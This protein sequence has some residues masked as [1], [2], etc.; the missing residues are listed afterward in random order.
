MN[1]LYELKYTLRM[2]RKKLGFS[3]LCVL[4]IALGFPIALP[5]YSIVK[6]F[7]YAS[8]PYSGGDRIVVL[9][10]LDTRTNREVGDTT[11]DYFLFNGIKERSRSFEKLGAYQNIV[12]NISDGEFAQQYFGHRVTSEFLSYAE[13]NPI[14]GRSLLPEDESS[15][16][17]PVVLISYRIWQEYYT[18]DPEIVGKIARVNAQP[19]TII[20][21]MP[22]GFKYPS[23]AE[24][25]LPFSIPSFSEPGTQ[26]LFVM[27][28]ILNEGVSRAEASVELALIMQSLSAEAPGFYENRSA[29]A[30]RFTQ[31]GLNNGAWLIKSVAITAICLFLVICIN[32][33]NLLILR[34]N[35]RVSELAIRSA[36]GAK[37]LSL[38][39][40]VLLESFLVCFCGAMLGISFAGWVLNFLQ[41]FLLSQSLDGRTLP[42]WWNFGFTQEVFYLSTILMLTLWLSSGIFAAWRASKDGISTVL[43]KNSQMGGGTSS[44][45]LTQSLVGIQIVLSFFLLV[46]S[47]VYVFGFQ[48][49]LPSSVVSNPDNYLTATFD[50]DSARYR[51]PNQRRQY[52]SELVQEL[53]QLNEF[54]EISIATA[55]PGGGSEYSRAAVGDAGEM[56]EDAPLMAVNWIDSQY[57]D[58]ISFELFGGRNFDT[59]DLPNGDPVAIV[60]ESFA[61][62]ML[63][64]SDS[65]LGKQ[66]RLKDFSGIG[67]DFVTIIGVAPLASYDNSALNISQAPIIYRPIAQQNTASALKLIVKLNLATETP[68]IE[69]ENLVRES[70]ALIDRDVPFY[71]FELMSTPIVLNVL[72]IRTLMIMFAAAAVGSLLLAVISI[73][74]LISRTVHARTSEIGIR[75]AIGSPDSAIRGMFLKQALLY[76]I[77]AVIVGGGSAV[78]VINVLGS[79][80]SS[81]LNFVQ[82]LTIVFPSVTAAI[83]LL[84]FYASYVPVR[85]VVAMEP[86]EALHYE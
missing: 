10:Q 47:G 13:T 30:V 27:S 71:T 26:P 19:H 86:G 41:G 58:A 65:L 2:I 84:V 22:D 15:G 12:T 4:V 83:S 28:G 17:E 3:I 37:R 6:N 52:R 48:G 55:L 57:F 56:A 23:A 64:A 25:W 50:L 36:M 39:S 38:I 49:V 73:Y 32:V 81:A 7:A 40:H 67:E 34:A 63:M 31:A 69:L 8:L 20:G 59:G 53:S 42:F 60:S 35:E 54:S 78:L 5:L 24:I 9:K 75:R 77:V 14:L 21:V 33:G 43:A 18:G 51:I 11:F 29:A 68:L 61:G 74:G 45:R 76:V 85:G 44:G 72:F 1:F 66:I 62:R 46:L 16:A 79:S 82:I 80:L 70:A